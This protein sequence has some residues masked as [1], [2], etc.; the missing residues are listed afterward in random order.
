MTTYLVLGDERAALA[1][2][3]TQGDPEATR[4]ESES[5]AASMQP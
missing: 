5:I 2:F 3:G 1:V 4:S